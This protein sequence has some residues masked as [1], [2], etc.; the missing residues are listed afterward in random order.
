MGPSCL[1]HLSKHTSLNARVTLDQYIALHSVFHL[2]SDGGINTYLPYISCFFH[3]NPFLAN[4]TFLA[5]NP[6]FALLLRQSAS[7]FGSSSNF[8]STS[9]KAH[10]QCVG[11]STHA[12][13]PGQRYLSQVAG[14][15]GSA[16]GRTIGGEGGK[17]TVVKVPLVP[18]AVA[19]DV[20]TAGI[21]VAV[22]VAAGGAALEHLVEEGAELRRG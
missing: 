2:S 18:C 20:A 9:G 3:S 16:R 4:S 21:A 7:P 12:S 14:C 10:G 8:S 17:N 11:L 15:V 5:V 1:F 22:T 19:G 6:F 13:V